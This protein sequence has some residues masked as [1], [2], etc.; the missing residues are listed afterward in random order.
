MEESSKIYP[1]KFDLETQADGALYDL[2]TFDCGNDQ[3]LNGL[4]EK[5]PNEPEE[6]LW[7]EYN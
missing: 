7:E 5:E 6:D 2:D 3:P 4:N 1:S